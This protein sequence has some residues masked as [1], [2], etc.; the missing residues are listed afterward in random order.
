MQ[1]DLSLVHNEQFCQVEVDID[2]WAAKYHL[3]T[4]HFNGRQQV[5][6]AEFLTFKLPILPS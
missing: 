2:M 4:A 5:M 6:K 3:T 1:Y